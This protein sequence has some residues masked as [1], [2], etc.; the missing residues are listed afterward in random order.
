MPDIRLLAASAFSKL[1]IIRKALCLF[2][3]PV[4]VMRCFK[5]ILLPMLLYCSSELKSD[6]AS[7]LRLFHQSVSKAMNLLMVWWCE[8]SS[9][10]CTVH[11]SYESA[12]NIDKRNHRLQ[13]M[14]NKYSVSHGHQYR[15]IHNKV[16]LNIATVKFVHHRS[17]FAQPPTQD[18]H[19]S[20]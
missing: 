19:R 16:N 4:L 1:G 5:R 15:K 14:Y 17:R 20:F 10:D 3:D 9:T 12:S 7:H 11:V 18:N 8:T 13:K 2:G 6:V